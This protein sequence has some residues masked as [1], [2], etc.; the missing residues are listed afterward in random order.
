MPQLKMS[1]GEA[2]VVKTPERAVSQ[3]LFGA[4]LVVS[5]VRRNCATTV[6]TIPCSEAEMHWLRYGSFALAHD[7]NFLLRN[8]GS[9]AQ[10]RRRARLPSLG[11]P[12][13]FSY[14]VG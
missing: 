5:L 3:S 14:P 8:P 13:D 6:T 7:F 11:P 12:F 9:V 10:S 1:G 4:W 2:G